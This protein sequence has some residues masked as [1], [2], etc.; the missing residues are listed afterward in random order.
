MNGW[1][2]KNDLSGKSG[3]GVLTLALLDISTRQGRDEL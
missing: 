2:M 3:Q 1:K